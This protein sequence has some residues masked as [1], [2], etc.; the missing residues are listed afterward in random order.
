MTTTNHETFRC[1]V[2]CLSQLQIFYSLFS[3]VTQKKKRRKGKNGRRVNR[4]RD[5][6]AMKICKEMREDER[7]KKEI[8][9][10]PVY[11][12]LLMW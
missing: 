4:G 1:A 2:F 3:S 8:G 9:I 11:E 7:T 10:Q 5:R 6:Q 12:I